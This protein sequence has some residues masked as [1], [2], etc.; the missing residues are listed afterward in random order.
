MELVYDIL[1]ILHFVGL[2][3]LLGGFLVQLSGSPRLVNRAMVDGAMTQLVTG[4]ALVG[5][6]EAALDE[7]L[8]HAKIGVKLAVLAVIVV[9]TWANRKR[10][11]VPTGV[12]AAIGGLTLA[13]IAIAV[14]V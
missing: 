14:L 12:W 3:S 2:A 6:A 4:L 9:L 8:N 10:A 1:V 11:A 13:N 7:D 5:I